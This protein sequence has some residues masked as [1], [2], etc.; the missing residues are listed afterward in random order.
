MANANYSANIK[1]TSKELTKKQQAQL[2]QA[3]FPTLDKAVMSDGTEL[4]IDIDFYAIIQVHNEKTENKDYEVCV[5]FCKDGSAYGTGSSSFIQRLE[6]AMEYMEDS[7]EEWK[8]AVS[9][10]NSK[11]RTGAQF[12]SCRVI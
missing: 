8:L 4:V 3:D 6:E 2:L 11:T 1:Y 12:L 7:D 9:K 10:K 5:V